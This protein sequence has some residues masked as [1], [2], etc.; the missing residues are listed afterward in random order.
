MCL[1]L[2][3][4]PLENLDMIVGSW[5]SCMENHSIRKK[6]IFCSL[7]SALLVCPGGIKGK[8]SSRFWEQRRKQ[9]SQ[10]LSFERP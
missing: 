10:G 3:F 9:Q 7:H 2:K 5:E 1:F 4:F 6:Y 8:D